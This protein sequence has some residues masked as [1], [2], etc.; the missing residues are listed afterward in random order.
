MCQQKRRR[1]SYRLLT[2][3]SDPQ[4][5]GKWGFLGRHVFAPRD[6]ANPHDHQQY[7]DNKQLAHWVAD[8]DDVRYSL[9]PCICSAARRVWNLQDME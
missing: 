3:A 4:R 9:N 8:P 6:N 7:R 1:F 5:N 2:A